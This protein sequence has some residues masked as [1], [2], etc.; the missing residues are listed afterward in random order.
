MSRLPDH[1]EAYAHVERLY[2]AHR[3]PITAY[4][5]RLVGDHHAAEDLCQETFLKA[6]RSWAQHDPRASAVGWLYRIATNAAYDSLRRRNVLRW[7]SL[8]AA[9]G[10]VDEA[11]GE[12]QLVDG[13]ALRAALARLPQRYRAPLLLACG[14]YSADEIADALQ[15]SAAAVR[16]RL[17]RAR[18]RLRQFEG[19]WV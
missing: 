7:T 14:G 19:D 18:A 4:L 11:A 2:L 3:R 1:G 9:G 8:D 10:G 6:M 16:M 17:H 12:D 13:A 5:S 15:C